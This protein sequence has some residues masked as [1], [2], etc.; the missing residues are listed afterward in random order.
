MRVGWLGQDP[1]WRRGWHGT[2][3]WICG[4]LQQPGS[5]A[6]LGRVCSPALVSSPA[7]L[8]LCPAGRCPGA[9]GSGTFTASTARRVPFVPFVPY[10]RGCGPGPARPRR[11]AVVLATGPAVIDGSDKQSS[12]LLC[13]PA[14]SAAPC[15]GASDM[16]YS[17]QH[18]ARERRAAGGTLGRGA[19]WGL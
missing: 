14:P 15:R 18:A 4:G 17:S 2:G 1:V 3:V 7:S 9:L 10:L 6:G 8:G 12:A 19:W 16:N 13:R 11:R 5:G